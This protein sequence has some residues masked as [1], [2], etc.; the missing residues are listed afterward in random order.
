[1]SVPRVVLV[2]DHEM[3]RE[4]LCTALVSE[5]DIEV[6]G[7]AAFAF[8]ATA[9]TVE[10]LLIALADAWS[11][12]GDPVLPA[13]VAQALAQGTD[14]A[15]AQARLRQARASRDLALTVERSIDHQTG[16]LWRVPT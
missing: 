8:W 7:E 16:G 4:A 10:A 2:D 14:V 6:V 13:L 1:M 3:V 12:F 9:P 5:G 11:H 15:A